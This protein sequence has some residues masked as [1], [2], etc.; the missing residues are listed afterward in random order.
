MIY[1]Y[2]F[3]NK[4][5][6]SKE[7]FIP[8]PESDPILERIKQKVDPQTFEVF[9]TTIDAYFAEAFAYQMEKEN[10]IEVHKSRWDKE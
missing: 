6:V 2:D 4:K 7:E 9:Q 5:L 10:G 8:K 3:V 1:N